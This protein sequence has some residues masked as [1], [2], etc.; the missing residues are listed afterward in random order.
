MQM[1]P[2]TAMPGV[3]IINYPPKGMCDK[4]RQSFD[5]GVGGTVVGTVRQGSQ[6]QFPVHAGMQRVTLEKSGIGGAISGFFSG[7][8]ESA[9]SVVPVQPGQQ[10]QLSIIWEENMCE[11]RHGGRVMLR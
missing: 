2:P 5:I 7:S 9:S 6:G 4:R 3:L 1:A 8:K 11:G 10:V